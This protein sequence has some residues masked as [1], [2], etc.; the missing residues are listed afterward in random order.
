MTNLYISFPFHIAMVPSPQAP[1]QA[2]DN[3]QQT[4]LTNWLMDMKA[5]NPCWLEVSTCLSNAHQFR[6]IL[7]SWSGKSEVFHATE[8]SV[9]RESGWTQHPT[10]WEFEISRKL[11][12]RCCWSW[13]R[14]RISLADF[15][16]FSW[17][18]KHRRDQHQGD[19][20]RWLTLS[21]QGLKFFHL[22]AQV[23]MEWASTYWENRWNLPEMSHQFG[24][25]QD[26]SGSH[27]VRKPAWGNLKFAGRGS[28]SWSSS[29][30]LSSGT[31]SSGAFQSQQLHSVQLK[32]YIFCFLLHVFIAVH[33]NCRP[34][35]PLHYFPWLPLF[36]V[37]WCSS[38]N[39]S[40]SRSPEPLNP[41]C[42]ASVV[43]GASATF[44]TSSL[45]PF[46]RSEQNTSPLAVGALLSR[47]N[48]LRTCAPATG[49]ASV[50]LK[51]WRFGQSIAIHF[52]G[53]SSG[54][55]ADT[56]ATCNGK[57]LKG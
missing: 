55:Y 28:R 46:L 50:A 7:P 44:T 15:S 32:L 47:G 36:E 8:A 2:E 49:A 43:P 10:C 16:S 4:E 51:K 31:L 13:W 20:C 40:V 18:W 53:S 21:F 33:P 37:S 57:S 52:S 35:E 23:R 24:V 45:Q 17:F 30:A 26:S 27:K 39:H 25:H 1:G 48:P 9:Q 14:R 5:P 34:L 11:W 41:P 56:D 3:L 12:P 42:R 6:I 29:S 54:L 19:D 22:F 38:E